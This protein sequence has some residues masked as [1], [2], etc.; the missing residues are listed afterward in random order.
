MV[1]PWHPSVRVLGQIGCVL[2]KSSQIIKWID[3][4]QVAC[5]DQAHKKIPNLGAMFGF[6]KEGILA[7]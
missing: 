2:L 7:M 3:L 5:V 4:N 6:V 1:I